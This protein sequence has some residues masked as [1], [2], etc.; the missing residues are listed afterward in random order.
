MIVVRL[1][2]RSPFRQTLAVLRDGLR[3]LNRH[4]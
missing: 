2:L 3:N 4:T 1:G